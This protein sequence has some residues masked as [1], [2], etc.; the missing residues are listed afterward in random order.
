MKKEFNSLA[1]LLNVK[2]DSERATFKVDLF[3]GGNKE[4]EI[5][6]ERDNEVVK[7][8][9]KMFDD[10]DISDRKEEEEGEDDLLDLMDKAANK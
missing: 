8:V 3:K 5:E 9:N 7:K 4:D 2:G 6:I 1:D 10:F